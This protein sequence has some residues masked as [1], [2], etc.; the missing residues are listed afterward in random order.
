MNCVVK[1]ILF[2]VS[3]MRT[4]WEREALETATEQR[5]FLAPARSAN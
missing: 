3:V 2:R 4:R 5:A 1:L